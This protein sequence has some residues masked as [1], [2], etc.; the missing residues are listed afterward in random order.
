M[1]IGSP[2][3]LTEEK[4]LHNFLQIFLN[5]LFSLKNKDS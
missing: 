2:D 3:R 4:Y 5:V 1:D